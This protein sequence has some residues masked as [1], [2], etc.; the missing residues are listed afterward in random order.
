[1]EGPVEGGDGRASVLDFLGGPSGPWLALE[2]F[3]LGATAAFFL[4]RLLPSVID[5]LSTR[6]PSAE[7]SNS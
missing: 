5:C 7:S 3:R 6:C 4:S 1:M 2:V